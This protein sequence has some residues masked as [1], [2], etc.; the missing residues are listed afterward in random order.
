MDPTTAELFMADTLPVRTS[1][2]AETSIQ[3]RL[4]DPAQLFD[5]HYGQPLSPSPLPELSTSRHLSFPVAAALKQLERIEALGPDWDSYGSEAPDHMAVARAHRLI[6]ELYMWSLGARNCPVVPYAVVPLS[7]G[8]VQVEWRGRAAAIEV[9]IS[10]EGAFG[11]LLARGTEPSR[12]F[13]ERDNVT[14][15][16]ILELVRSVI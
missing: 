6:W 5:A 1:C 2:T 16:Q 9:E 4:L 3:P 14:E 13:E 11:Y 10:P 8:G 12:E 7:G 15:S